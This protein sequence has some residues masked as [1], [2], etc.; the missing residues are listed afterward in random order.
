MTAPTSVPDAIDR[1]TWDVLVVGAGIAGLTTAITAAEHGARV[2]VVEKEPDVG[3]STVLS[4]GSF[5][6]AGT[7]RQ[8]EDGIVDSSELLLADLLEVGQ[9]KN[10]RDLVET[11]VE[12]D[13]DAYAWLTG[14]GVRFGPVQAAAGQSVPR[15]HPTDPRAVIDILAQR[16]AELPTIVLRTGVAARRLTTDPGT[17]RVDGA[18]VD[19]DGT[20][21]RISA[22]AVVLA[23]GGFSRNSAM[24]DQFVPAQAAALHLGGPGNYGDGLRMAQKVGADL[25]DLPYIKG[26][27]G[28]SPGAL[29]HEHTTCIAVYKGAVAVN[30]RGKRFVDESQS[31]KLLGDACLG[32]EGA[33]AYQVFDQSIFESD[34]PGYPMFDFHLRLREGRLLT[35]ET[36]PGLAEAIGV[37]A[38]ALVQTIDEY[39]EIANG[40]RPDPFGRTH[41]TH[42]YG[43][44]ARIERAPFYAYPSTSAIVATYAGVSIDPRAQ[45]LDVFGEPVAGLFAVGEMTGGFHGAAYMTGTSLGKAVVFGRIAGEAALAACAEGAA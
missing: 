1:A 26:T 42:Q 2:L 41:L 10:R 8:D 23:A 36:L 14:L 45:V 11:Y 25:V 3:G 4:G 29:A 21:R 13:R 6:F 38:D 19:E 24:L 43:E 32:Q 5:A 17:G 22:A 40:L 7:T 31:Y 16:V 44:L 12:H 30:Q 37:P 28:S 39:N 33:V 27:F 35:A 15:A 20:Q 34:I 18:T 9:H